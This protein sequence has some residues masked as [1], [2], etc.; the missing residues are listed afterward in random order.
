MISCSIR[1]GIHGVRHFW[2][3][4]AYWNDA[5]RPMVHMGNAWVSE[6][7][8]SMPWAV[9]DDYGDLVAVPGPNA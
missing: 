7:G 2:I 4:F 3:A 9:M 5:R 8:V 1:H 6:S